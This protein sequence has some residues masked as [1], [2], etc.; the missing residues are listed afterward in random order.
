M[1]VHIITT[2]DSYRSLLKQLGKDTEKYLN[3]MD[4][5]E[6][7]DSNSITI[8]GK[9]FGVKGQVNGSSVYI[10]RRF[11]ITTKPAIWLKPYNFPTNFWMTQN[12]WT[13]HFFK[14]F[15]IFN[16]MHSICIELWSALGIFLYK[17]N[18]HLHYHFIFL[19]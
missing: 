18:V 15:N 17:F 8:E 11:R 14:K 2:T 10:V 12:G 5:Y 19:Y 7:D 6:V 3:T 1:Q 16:L 13:N 9:K 4:W